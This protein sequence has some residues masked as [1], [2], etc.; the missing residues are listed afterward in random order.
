MAPGAS[1]LGKEQS[2]RSKQLFGVMKKHVDKGP[3]LKAQKSKTLPTNTV[4]SKVKPSQS[5]KQ[6]SRSRI[7]KHA[8][9]IARSKGGN[10]KPKAKAKRKGS[11]GKNE[12]ALKNM[13][14][15]KIV[16]RRRQPVAYRFLSSDSS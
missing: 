9:K 8:T 3:H 15:A 6:T 11:T 5:S 14:T 7:Q 10:K 13:K 16:K 4:R 12:K 2:K 1:L